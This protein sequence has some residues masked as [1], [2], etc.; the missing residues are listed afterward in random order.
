MQGGGF[1]SKRGSPGDRATA[2]TVNS[3]T[4]R[5]RHIVLQLDLAHPAVAQQQARWAI[6]SAAAAVSHLFI[7]NDSFHTKC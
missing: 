4:R 6:C 2:A 1:R 3:Q 7:F 5:R